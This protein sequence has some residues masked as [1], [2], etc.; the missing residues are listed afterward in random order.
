MGDGYFDYTENYNFSKEMEERS[1]FH[2]DGEVIGQVELDN[3]YFAEL[4]KDGG[5]SGASDRIIVWLCHR[6]HKEKV[7]AF[8]IMLGVMVCGR[9][10]VLQNAVRMKFKTNYARLIKTYTKRY[11]STE[12]KMTDKVSVK[13]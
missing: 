6:E 3:G 7:Y 5:I 8:S 1:S 9:D 13:S 12:K 10:T 11:C 2:S 4:V